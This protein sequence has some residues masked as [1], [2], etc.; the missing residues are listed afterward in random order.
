[1]TPRVPLNLKPFGMAEGADGVARCRARSRIRASRPAVLS[2]LIGLVFEDGQ[3]EVGVDVDR[4]GLYRLRTGEHRGDVRG[5]SPRDMGVGQQPAPL[6]VDDEGRAHGRALLVLDEGRLDARLDVGGV[7]ARSGEDLFCA[8]T[9]MGCPAHEQAD[10]ENPE[11]HYARI[12]PCG[13]DP[14]LRRWSQRGD[15]E[16]AISSRLHQPLSSPSRC[17]AKKMPVCA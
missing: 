10:D 4:P 9:R 7:T 15:L 14:A 16:R 8:G 11:F 17:R 12:V 6:A 5:G 1:M 3:V 2:M 13:R